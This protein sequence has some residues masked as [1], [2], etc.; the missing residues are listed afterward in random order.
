MTH[1]IHEQAKTS[2]TENQRKKSR[3]GSRSMS[4]EKVDKILSLKIETED[5]EE[6]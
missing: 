6:N 4:K 1:V 5:E 3:P 2:E